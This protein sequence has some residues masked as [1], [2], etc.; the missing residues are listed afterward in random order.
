MKKYNKIN[1]ILGWIVFGIAAVVYILTSEPTMSF[2]DCGEYIATA[3]KLEV[4]HPPGAP[5]FQLLGRV[6]SLFAFSDVKHVA[7]MV[8]TM[9]ALCSGFT[10]LFLFWTITIFARKLI[11]KAGEELTNGKIYAIMGAGLVGSLAYTF[12]DSFWFS[13]VEGEVYAMSAFF[14]AV[15]FWAI[16]KWEEQAEAKHAY[17]WLVLIAYLVG[18]SVG[19]HL[20]NLLAIPA[21]TFVWYFKKHPQATWKTILLV[22][23]IS[24]AILAIVMYI[25]IPWVVKLAGL[26]ELLFVNSFGLPFN[27]GTIIYFVLLIGFIIWGL[28]YTRRKGRTILNTILLSLTFIII[29]YTSFLMLV[30]RS[31]ANTPLDENN[32]ENA[33]YLLAYL[34][35]EQYGDWPLFSGP[36][37]NAPVID[38]K[39][40]NPVYTKDDKSGKYIITDKREKVIPVFDSR[41]TTFFPRMWED[42]EPKHAVE[43]KKWANV[44]GKPVTVQSGEQEETRIVPTFTE[45]LRF[46]WKYQ[47]V[48]MYYRYFMW[49]FAGKQNDNQGMGSKIEGNWKSGIPFIDKIRL[50]DQHL[51]EI[52]KNKG[53]N[54]FYFL[55][56]I[57]GIL[58]LVYHVR[59][60]QRSSLIVFLLFFMTGLAIL[61]YLNQYAPQPRE[62]DYAYAGSFYA[63]A[64]WIGLGVTALSEWLSAR[65]KLKLSAILVTVATLILVPGIMAQQGWNDHDRSGRYTGLAMAKDYLNSCARNAILFTNGDNDTFPLWYAQEVEGVR[66]DVRVVNLSLLNTDWYIDQMKRKAYDSDPVPFSLSKEKYR[67][68]N[69]D[70]V[71]FIENEGLKDVYVDL[72]DLFHVLN[73]DES[74][75]KFNTSQYGMIDFFPSKKFMVTYD[76]QTFLKDH[77]LLTKYRSRLD[78]IRWE[79]DRQGIQ[80][81]DLMIL[82]LLGENKWKRPV[83]FAMTMGPESYLGLDKYFHLEGIAYHLLPIKAKAEEGEMGEVNTEAMY[84]NLMNKFVFGNMQNPKVYMDENNMRMAMNLRNAF[85][86]LANALINE[87]KK[88]SA[89]RVLDRCL[90]VMPENIIPSNYFMASIADGYY[91]IGETKKADEMAERLYKLMNEDLAYIFSFP[92]KDLQNSDASAQEDLMTMQRLAMVARDNK[93]RELSDKSQACLEKY[94]QLFTD[95]IKQVQR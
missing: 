21:I 28:I 62:R 70:I 47:I 3:Y 92:D 5:L 81:N 13:A 38:R 27:S 89:K 23:A 73:T 93:Q 11:L 82:D 69:H 60:D 14:T 74:K 75:L 94:F 8:N 41:F 7:R 29:G 76:P 84:N 68:G 77:P 25:I 10:I 12:S 55:P 51:P 35:R 37:Y 56:L 46:F 31:N 18:L 2:W 45:N 48:H 79:I 22:V 19:V 36:Y 50:G 72:K 24:I 86:R 63:F 4:G 61:L 26:S 49:N 16:L 78:T 87:G 65:I 83:Y 90:E 57:L 34:N 95:K 53:D 43:Y 71:Y 66:T 52:R 6:F 30:I 85:G 59:K 17:R 39:D 64:I 40:G 9:S 88:D 54:S 1:T 80:K 15:V 33:M 32:P 58:G 67:Q 20:L 91:R 42:K 44:I